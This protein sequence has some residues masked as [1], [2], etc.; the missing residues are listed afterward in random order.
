ML[1]PAM[2]ARLVLLP[3]F[4]AHL[5]HA[6]VLRFNLLPALARP[7]DGGRTMRGRRLLG[8]NKTWR[9]AAVMFGGALGA[10]AALWRLPS[11]RSRLPRELRNS[12]SVVTG[13]LLG[14]GVVLGELPNSF[15]KRQLDIPAGA[16]HRSVAGAAL[17]LFDQ[18]DFV[19]LTWL[20]LRPAYKLSS[21]QALDA[22]AFVTAVHLPV[23]V[24]GYLIGART[25][26]I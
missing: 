19:F 22:A 9:G 3:V 17:A 12:R 8:D 25:T 21:R 26:P 16:R 20:L 23:N 15:L 24:I 7:M 2:H 13:S 14:A 10:T 11:Y 5:A 6:P 18:S 4:G 1:R